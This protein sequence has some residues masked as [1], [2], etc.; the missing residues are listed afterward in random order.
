MAPRCGHFV[1]YAEALSMQRSGKSPRHLTSN[2]IVASRW[3]AHGARPR[4]RGA[5][6]RA[7][8]APAAGLPFTVRVAVV[9]AHAAVLFAEDVAP[10]GT[11]VLA[12]AAAGRENSM[13]MT[14]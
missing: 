2:L 6:Y 11:V 4:L 5:R 14:R 8:V 1:V 9:A 3:L 12:L 13:E 7:R 10:Q